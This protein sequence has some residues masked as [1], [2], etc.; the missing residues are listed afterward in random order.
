M[1]SDI[2]L[3]FFLN[4]YKGCFIFYHIHISQTKSCA[5]KRIWYHKFIIHCL[6]LF[7]IKAFVLN[8]FF[9]LVMCVWLSK[10]IKDQISDLLKGINIPYVGILSKSGCY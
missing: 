2:L 3:K 9:L 7:L 6:H 5:L 1:H 10:Y 8:W 4:S